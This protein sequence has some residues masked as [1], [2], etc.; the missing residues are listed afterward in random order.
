MLKILLFFIIF[1]LITVYSQYLAPPFGGVVYNRIR[2]SG[3][4]E[5]ILSFID[6]N[7]LTNCFG[8]RVFSDYLSLRCMINGKVRDIILRV[9]E[10]K[11]NVLYV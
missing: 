3:V 11:E 6:D 7:H 10:E 1:N 2:P 5:E 4:Y 9:L 8:K